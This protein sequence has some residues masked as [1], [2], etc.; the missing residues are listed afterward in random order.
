MT[1]EFYIG[2]HDR[3]GAESGRRTKRTVIF[4]LLL[5]L[6]L[7]AALVF[8]MKGFSNA[9]FEFGVERS[10]EGVVEPGAVP[11][12]RVDRPG[13]AWLSEGSSRY[14]LVAFGKRGAALEL[15]DTGG[16]SVRL[17]GSLI[18]RDGQTMVEV[19]EGSVEDLGPAPDLELGE[20]ELGT[21]ELVG[22]IVDSKCFLGV[23]KPGNLKPHRACAVRCISGGIPPVF[24][25]RDPEGAASYF[26]L[27]G[28]DGSAVNSE[29]LDRVAEP[30]RVEGRVVQRGG[31]RFLYADPATFRSA[32]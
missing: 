11:V 31:L 22:E 5:G 28:E 16:R 2:Y 30:L 27:V 1:D 7:G 9:V 14:L 15:A 21:R 26:L 3:M 8:S 23:M 18:Y 6:G 24:L 32:S 12:L 4:V 19:A 29:V 17:K 20:V 25:V 13:D 10:F